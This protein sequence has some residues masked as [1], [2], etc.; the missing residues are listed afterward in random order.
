MAAFGR[1]QIF[2]RARPFGRQ[3]LS[4]F[5]VLLSQFGIRSC[6]RQLTLGFRQLFLRPIPFATIIGVVQSGQDG[7]GWYRVADLH[8]ASLSRNRF[9]DLIE[10][11]HRSRHLERQVHFLQFLD[12]GAVSHLFR[13]RLRL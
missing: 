3:R 6:G 4:T 11:L 5:Q 13:K 9:V 10:L 7:L 12:R 2:L 1:I 8:V